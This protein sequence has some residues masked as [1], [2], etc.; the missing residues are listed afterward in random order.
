MRLA[1]TYIAVVAF[2]LVGVVALAENNIK[3]GVATIMLAGAN[4]LLLL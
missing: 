2:A 4:A 1:F 3:V